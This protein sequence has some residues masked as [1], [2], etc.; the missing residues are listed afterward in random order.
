ME[1]DVPDCVPTLATGTDGWL[2]DDQLF[3][4]NETLAQEED[5]QDFEEVT[6]I[7]ANASGLPHQIAAICSGMRGASADSVEVKYPCSKK[8]FLDR[9]SSMIKKAEERGMTFHPVSTGAHWILV[10]YANDCQR[11]RGCSSIFDPYAIRPHQYKTI[12]SHLRNQGRTVA[13]IPAQP[14]QHDNWS[15][16]YHVANV[17]QAFRKQVKNGGNACAR[18]LP[19]MAMVPCRPRAKGDQTQ[20]VFNRNE[21]E[22][23]Q[24]EAHFRCIR[25]VIKEK[26]SNST[27][28]FSRPLVWYKHQN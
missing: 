12:R 21:V 27:V 1:E 9:S 19:K 18:Y 7:I 5:G 16:G 10:T 28:D 6:K 8:I 3:F 11:H 20:R 24:A 4:M 23:F 25:R 2:K 17:I 14:I 26:I 13:A 15:C 22:I